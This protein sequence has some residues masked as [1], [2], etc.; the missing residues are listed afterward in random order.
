MNDRDATEKRDAGIVNAVISGQ[1]LQAVGDTYGISRERVRQIVKRVTGNGTITVRGYSAAKSIKVR[2]V[3]AEIDG[4][5]QRLLAGERTADIASFYGVSLSQF[6]IVI[7]NAGYRID[8]LR[9]PD[10]WDWLPEA[11]TLLDQRLS[12]E[13]IE[14]EFGIPRGKIQYAVDS[15]RLVSY[16]RKHE[17]TWVFDEDD[18]VRR[19]TAGESL[20]SVAHSIDVPE[21]TVRDRLHDRIPNR[22]RTRY[23]IASD[24][25]HLRWKSGESISD[26]ARSLGIPYNSVWSRIDYRRRRGAG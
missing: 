13:T 7:N 17:R 3:E 4:I 21:A 26:I 20:R 8:A 24:D 9:H 1:S 19:I 22:G 14:R 5:V 18:A 2:T 11:Q 12:Y 16:R 10:R 6:C 25:I 23:E 15:G